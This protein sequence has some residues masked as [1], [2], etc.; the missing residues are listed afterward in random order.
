MTRPSIVQYFG[1]IKDSK[2]SLVLS[3]NWPR[4]LCNKQ[5]HSD[6]RHIYSQNRSSLLTTKTQSIS[7][8]FQPPSK[9]APPFSSWIPPQSIVRF[10]SKSVKEKEFHKHLRRKIVKGL[11][12]TVPRAEEDPRKLVH[13]LDLK[14]AVYQHTACPGCGWKLQ[15]S[16]PDQLGYTIP[17]AKRLSKP[18]IKSK[19]DYRH[20]FQEDIE[21]D[22]YSIEE[23][24]NI[25]ETHNISE[26]EKNAT[27]QR[28]FQLKHYGKLV[29]VKV[30][31]EDFRKNLSVLTNANMI[32]L[33][34]VDILDFSGSF[35]DDFRDIV[36]ENPVGILA[37]KCDL[38]PNVMSL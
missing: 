36:G 31:F 20:F 4:N 24:D 1:K 26:A 34:V 10:A 16:F 7:K 14:G 25:K 27:C 2:V 9:L 35:V 11:E 5:S 13:P 32:A 15:S 33:K 17:L 37:N 3:G 8:P 23:M 21:E 19:H 38:L 30:P 6:N 18:K 29:P 22:E 28:C 12:K